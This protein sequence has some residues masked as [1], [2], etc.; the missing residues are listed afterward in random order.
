MPAVVT[1]RSRQSYASDLISVQ[2]NFMNTPIERITHYSTNVAAHSES[3][4]IKQWQDNGPLDNIR[5]TPFGP[6]RTDYTYGDSGSYLAD[7]IRKEWES[8]NMAR[9]PL[10]ALV[11][12]QK[13]T[14]LRSHEKRMSIEVSKLRDRR[15]SAISVA[16]SAVS[17]N[18]DNRE[19][20]RDDETSSRGSNISSAS[21]SRTLRSRCKQIQGEWCTH[22]E[23]MVIETAV[24]RLSV[25]RQRNTN[26]TTNLLV[27]QDGNNTAVNGGRTRSGRRSARASAKTTMTTTQTVQLDPIDS[28]TMGR[29]QHLGASS[30]T[31]VYQY[32]PYVDSAD[33]ALDLT[34]Q[35][36]VS[37]DGPGRTGLVDGTGGELWSK[38]RSA[39]WSRPV[40]LQPVEP[41]ITTHS[42]QKFSNEVT[43]GSCARSWI[44]RHI[45]GEIRFP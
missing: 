17:H 26:N 9:L 41:T 39:T 5:L 16:S 29:V 34:T 36:L 12:P 18:Q 1:R 13:E 6:E 32:V 27:V 19:S 28:H 14:I 22:T 24:R 20:E 45:F 4:M 21:S 38:R 33:A 8:P 25:D 15:K 31:Y 42:C 40:G 43:N 37:G 30:S 44:A 23:C 7:H 35:P 2:P 10:R 3:K 11:E